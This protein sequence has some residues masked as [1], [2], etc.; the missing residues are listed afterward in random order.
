MT[1]EYKALANSWIM[2]AACLPGV[3][4]VIYQAFLIFR[5]S[6]NDALRIGLSEKQVSSSIRSAAITSIGP[7]LVMI[8]AMLALMMYDGAPFAWLRTN[9]IGS[10]T[11][12][13]QGAQFAADGIGI[14]L[15]SSAMDANFLATAC[16]V[17]AGGCVGWV[18]FSAL[19]SDKMEVVNE[20]LAGGNMLAVPIIGTGALIGVYCSLTIDRVIP[21]GTQVYGVFAGALAMYLL[22]LYDRKVHKQW[23]KEWGLT[24]CMIIG[25]LVCTVIDLM[26]GAL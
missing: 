17:E 4:I 7:C 14:E 12:E 22:T 25:M 11:Y 9:F 16:I 20:K 23:I 24:I 15:G 2:W 6:K 13:L 5:K 21:Y 3:A 1:A 18:I 8:T 26:T 10:I 19:F